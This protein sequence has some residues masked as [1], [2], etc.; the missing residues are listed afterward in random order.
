MRASLKAAFAAVMVFALLPAV[1]ATASSLV[2][3][4]TREVGHGR[5]RGCPSAWC[6]CYLDRT[7]KKVG[8]KTLG[9]YA[10]RDFARYGRTAK[11]KQVGAIMVMPH[12]VGVVV[13]TCPDGRVKLVSGNHGHKVGTGCYSA[14]KAIA[15][16]LPA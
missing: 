7:L 11:P 10:A 8:L 4:M 13:G 12:H 14:G 9:S 1:P 6:A 16:R 15:W 3:A 5:P 2:S